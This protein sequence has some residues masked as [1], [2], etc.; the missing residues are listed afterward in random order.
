[1]CLFPSL[2]LTSELCITGDVSPADSG[3]TDLRHK[4]TFQQPVWMPEVNIAKGNRME[5]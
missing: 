3:E 5:D 4:L 2:T 1:M